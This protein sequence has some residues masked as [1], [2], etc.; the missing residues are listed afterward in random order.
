[1]V[2]SLIRPTGPLGAVSGPQRKARLKRAQVGQQTIDRLGDLLWVQW[3]EE[4][5]GRLQPQHPVKA[6]PG[7]LAGSRHTLKSLP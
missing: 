7:A 1:M 4:I 5:I 2:K 3:L 6:Y